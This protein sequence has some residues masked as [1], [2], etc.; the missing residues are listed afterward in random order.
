MFPNN[1]QQRVE[2]SL[3]EVIRKI[4][5]GQGY[6]PDIADSTLFPIDGN[7]RFTKVAQTNWDNAI[8]NIVSTKG[9][10]VEIFG[11][12]S[13]FSK[14]LKRSPRVVIVPKRIIP[15]E[16]GMPPGFFYEN[17]NDSS[18]P[19]D[20]NKTPYPEES[21]NMHFDIHLVSSSQEQSRFL[22]T[23][24]SVSLGQKKYI[25]FEDDTTERFFIKHY[26]YYD[27]SDTNDGIEEN[28]YSYEVQDLYLFGNMVNI[29][30]KPILEIDTQIIIGYEPGDEMVAELNI[31]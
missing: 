2:R 14:G 23:L 21:S 1:I 29:R 3:F 4:V 31:T 16:I 27:I 12:S 24:L 10:A 22:N 15:G 17:A 20:Y 8:D 13:A 30:I 18:N 11:A 19:L 5:V 9:W 7:G 6:I 25:T 26:N 28:V